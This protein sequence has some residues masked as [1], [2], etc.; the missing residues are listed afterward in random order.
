MFDKLFKRKGKNKNRDFTLEFNNLIKETLAK[1]LKEIGFK[2]Q[3]NNFM[4]PLGDFTQVCNVQ[5]S[6]YNHIGEIRFTINFGFFIPVVYSVLG[7]KTKLPS[8]PKT[9]DCHIDGR[10]GHLI[11]GTD[12]WYELNEETSLETLTEQFK[13]DIK[14]HLIP[15]F[16]EIQTMDFLL[17]LIRTQYDKRKYYISPLINAVIILELEIGDF[18]IGKEKLISEYNETLIPKLVEGKRVY[19]DGTEEIMYSEFRVNEYAINRYKQLAE[20]YKIE[21]PK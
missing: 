11:Y 18:E 4:R 21:L 20:R 8:F 2:K 6:R 16:Q 10:T 7:D 12:Y 9:D 3:N 14:N 19:P 1:S 5:R 17:N 15:M 13:N